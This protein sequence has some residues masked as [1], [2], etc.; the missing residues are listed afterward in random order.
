MCV[1]ING[2]KTFLQLLYQHT[3]FLRS[4]QQ[5]ASYVSADAKLYR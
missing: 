3:H 1:I 5:N 4:F 2:E